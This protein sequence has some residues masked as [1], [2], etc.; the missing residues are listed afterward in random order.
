MT[1]GT[2]AWGITPYGLA[3]SVPLSIAS[4]HARGELVVRVALTRSAL[5]AMSSGAGDA[6]NPR[7]WT[8]LRNDTLFSFTVLSVRTVPAPVPNSVFELYLLQKLGPSGIDHTVKAL[9]LTDASG[10]LISAPKVMVFDGCQAAEATN[11]A[12]RN[13][14]VDLAKPQ[15][16]DGLGGAVFNV[17][18]SGDYDTESG[19]SLL[20]KLFLR[21]LTTN[22][23]EFFHLTG[24]GLGIALKEPLGAARLVA[25]KAEVERQLKLEPEVDSASVSVR[26]SA[27]GVLQITL[28]ARLSATGLEVRDTFLVPSVSL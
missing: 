19:V 23:S 13:S 28:A 6:L 16:N 12:S 9:A 26:L 10:G 21:R 15:L 3:A 5:A 4:A 2:S 24:Y 11:Q 1:W 7:T 20:R 22:P 27:G 8:V 17:G 14:L 25:L 18:A